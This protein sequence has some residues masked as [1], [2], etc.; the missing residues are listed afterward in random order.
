MVEGEPGPG[1][2]PCRVRFTDMAPTHLVLEV[3]SRGPS[4]LLVFDTW[5]PGWRAEVDGV[6]QPILRA[7]GMF[8]LV[9]LPARARRIALSYTPPGMRLGA[10]ASTLGLL[11]LAALVRLGWHRG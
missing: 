2:S 8:R 3:E 4:W 9:A 10:V 7:N 11:G 5:A 6:E 1:G